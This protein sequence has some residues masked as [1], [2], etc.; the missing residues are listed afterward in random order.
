MSLALTVN[1]DRFVFRIKSFQDWNNSSADQMA[2]H[3]VNPRNTLAIDSRGHVVSTPG[4]WKSCTAYPVA[5]YAIRP[6]TQMIDYAE[7]ER[8][9]HGISVLE[10]SCAEARK[11]VSGAAS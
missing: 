11:D 6:I 1:V 10:F 8:L 4:D 5:V 7:N 9:N 3:Q 2:K